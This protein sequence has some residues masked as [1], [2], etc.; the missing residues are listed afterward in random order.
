MSKLYND[1]IVKIDSKELDAWIKGIQDVKEHINGRDCKI[2]IR[3]VEREGLEI[4]CA[5][6]TGEPVEDYKRLMSLCASRESIG[7]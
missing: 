5:E 3:F 6:V 2:M 1:F 4:F 7:E